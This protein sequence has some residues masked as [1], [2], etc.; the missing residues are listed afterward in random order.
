M[1]TFY[2]QKKKKKNSKTSNLKQLKKSQN[3][4]VYNMFIFMDEGYIK[5]VGRFFVAHT[6]STFMYS[7]IY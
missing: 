3:V 2:R 6:S 4:D 5:F 1:K 7:V